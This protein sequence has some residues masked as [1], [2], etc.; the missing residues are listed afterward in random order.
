MPSRALPCLPLLLVGCASPIEDVDLLGATWC[1]AERTATVA[2][3]LDGDTV[4]LGTCGEGERIRMLGVAAPEIAHPGSPAQCYG[5]EAAAFTQDALAGREVTVA[6]DTEC[7]DIYGRTLAWLRITGDPTDRLAP[8][9][10]A[11]GVEGVADDGSFS[12][13]FNEL[14]V[15][16]G[17]ATVYDEAIAEDV[18]YDAQMQAAEDAAAAAGLGLWS[19]D[20]CP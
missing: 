12:V 1:A 3:A 16:A 13:L 6:F 9:I 2:C 4:D 18:R 10:T 8:L 14:V 11:L 5:D 7:T 17:Y 15:R 19:P 20:A